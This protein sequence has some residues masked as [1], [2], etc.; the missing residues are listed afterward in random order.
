[1]KPK[2]SEMD[3]GPI[4]FERF[5]A[6]LRKIVSVPKS[7]LASKKRAKKTSRLRPHKAALSHS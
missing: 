2:E 5:H 1:M 7:S 3:E 6:A 4:A